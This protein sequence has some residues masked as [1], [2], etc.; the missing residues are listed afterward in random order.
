MRAILAKAV[1]TPEDLVIQD[2]PDPVPGPGEVA[3]DIKAAA[4][5]FPDLL[6]VEGKYQVIP[7]HPFSP[8]KEGAGVVAALGEGV[9]GIALGDRVMVQAE[10][11]TYCERITQP[12][13][14]CFP[15]PDAMGFDEAAAIG[16]AFQ[17]SHFA[18]VAR[19][20]VKPGD[21]VLVTA[22]TGSVGLAAVQLAKAFGCTVI[23]GV[24][25]MSK[26]D[27]AL[28]AGAD[29]I[30][31]LS[32]GNLKEAVRDQIK[33]ATGMVDVVIEMVGGEAFNGAIRALDFD[34]RIV[35]VGFTGGQIPALKTNYVL[36][37][38][39]AVT[40]VNWSTYRDRDPAWVQRVQSE[41]FQLYL[42]GAISVPVQAR[43][44]MED[45]VKAFDV[46]R[47]RQIRGKV[48]LTMNS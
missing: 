4:V 32:E 9:Q 43:F 40:G 8:G 6:V 35:V 25:T 5:N 46:I 26:A 21:R 11:G 13:N 29:H 12:A 27:V 33:S 28:E 16:V 31:D 22:A 44:A 37:K 39:I 17:T 36:L 38:N 18:L 41:I 45:Y 3:V 42:D 15:V 10:W 24:T 1:G 2:L 19:A 34:G 14:L 48:V 30:I 7:P 47:D 20:A 23:A